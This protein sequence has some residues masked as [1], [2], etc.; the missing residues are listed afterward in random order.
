M[1]YLIGYQI[2]GEA[3]IY[4]EK[5]IEKICK[6]FKV[7]NLNEHIP[8]HFTLKSPFETKNINLIER[9]LKDF[10]N[11]EKS[12]Y[13]KINGIGSFNERIIY[14]NGILSHEAKN[15]FR[16]L[17]SE[18]QKIDWM[19][20]GDYDLR[21]DNFHS[22][23]ARA[24]DKK[25][26]YNIMDFLSKEKPYFKMNFDNIAIFEKTNDHWEVYKEFKIK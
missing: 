19:E 24:K 5:L 18:L 1:K 17:I 9:L 12:S 23:L 7:S 16:G 11:K 8:A 10:S 14:L 15:T 22:T 2:K 13:N 20:F 26:F 4:Q 6:N 25:Q 3:R 21:E